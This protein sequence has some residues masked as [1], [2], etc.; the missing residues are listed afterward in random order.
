MIN[1]G[2]S[3]RLSSADGYKERRDS[4]ARD[5]PKYFQK[6]F[7]E[8]N[9]LDDY[10]KRGHLFTKTNPVRERRKYPPT[11]DYKNFGLEESYVDIEFQAG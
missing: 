1:I 8:N 11:L 3:M 10:R 7:K 6:E 9:R 2:I 4:I 5:W